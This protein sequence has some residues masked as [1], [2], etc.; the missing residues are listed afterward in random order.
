MDQC[1]EYTASAFA[2]RKCDDDCGWRQ[3]GASRDTSR[4]DRPVPAIRLHARQSRLRRVPHGCQ[5]LLDDGTLRQCPLRRDASRLLSLES[6]AL[7]LVG[8]F[9]Q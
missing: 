5:T 3:R 2:D 7:Y 9:A 6:A 4:G 1:R 8:G